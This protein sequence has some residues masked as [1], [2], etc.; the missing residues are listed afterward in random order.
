MATR[1]NGWLPSALAP[2]MRQTSDSNYKLQPTR[3]NVS[4]IY[5][6]LQTLG[7]SENKQIPKNVA[8][9]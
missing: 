6:L 2:A 7:V 8:S 3:C 5:L 9:C 1:I 4:C